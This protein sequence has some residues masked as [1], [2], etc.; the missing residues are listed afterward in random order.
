MIQCASALGVT[1]PAPG[2]RNGTIFVL[3]LLVRDAN[4][5]MDTPP[6]DIEAP[7]TKSS[8]PPVPE[9]ILVPME[10]AQICP[11]RSTS[12]AELIAIMLGF[13]RI[14]HGSLTYLMSFISTSGLWS[15]NEYTSCDPRRKEATILPLSIFL[16][17]PFTTP[18]FIR[19]STPS[20]NISVWTPRFL[21]ST[22]C[23]ARALGRAPMP[24][25]MQAPSGTSSAQ[26]LPISTSVGVG[27]AKSLETNGVS[28]F[29]R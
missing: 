7:F 12:V 20:A 21:W 3:P 1:T 24:I 8:W 15:M 5:V 28:S 19:R 14:T 13:W 4:A 17:A 18:F 29:T 6:S 22:S 25:W 27:S 23:A 2:L 9:N 16:L 10:S 11:V 26:F